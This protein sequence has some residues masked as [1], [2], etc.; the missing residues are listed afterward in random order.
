MGGPGSGRQS[1]KTPEACAEIVDR[2]SDGE[3]LAKICR[4]AHMPR[5]STAYA[6]MQEDADFAGEVARA[7]DIGY[8][9]I[10]MDTMHIADDDARDWE[11]VRDGD[12]NVV[13]VRVD[14][15]HVTRSKLRIETRLKL[16][17]CWDPRRYGNRQQL[18]HTGPGG[19]PVQVQAVEWVV[20]PA[21]TPDAKG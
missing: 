20:V 16:L 14:G 6:W 11:T 8:D 7:R 3:P 4:D 5:V 13:G 17:S 18:E 21:S 10:A 12:G 9:V 1:T 15:E 2:L 19:G